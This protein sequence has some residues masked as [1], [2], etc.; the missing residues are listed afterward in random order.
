MRWTRSPNARVVVGGGDERWWSGLGEQGAWRGGGGFY[1]S[2]VAAAQ[3]RSRGA[4][5]C[6]GMVLHLIVTSG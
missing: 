2:P 6:A 4:G 3:P 1:T 5:R